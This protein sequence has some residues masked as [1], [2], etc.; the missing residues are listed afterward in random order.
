MLHAGQ[1]PLLSVETFTTSTVGAQGWVGLDRMLAL[2][3]IFTPNEVEARSIIGDKAATLSP[4]E[5][6]LT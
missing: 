4:E 5:V 1:S 2:V 6:R 3:D